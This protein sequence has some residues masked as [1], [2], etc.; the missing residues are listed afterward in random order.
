MLQYPRHALPLSL[1]TRNG[2]GP[3]DI[4]GASAALLWV[5]RPFAVTS[6]RVLSQFMRR[7]REDDTARLC[8]GRLRVANVASRVISLSHQSSLAT[9]HVDPDELEHIDD[10]VSFYNPLRW[11]PT[12]PR[13]SEELIVMGYTLDQWPATLTFR[14]KVERVEPHRVEAQLVESKMPGRLPG[15]CGAPVYR[16]GSPPEFVGVVVDSMFHN[17]L[18]HIQHAT[19]LDPFGRALTLE[20]AAQ[21]S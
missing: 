21:R 9:L 4:H 20:A 3:K 7:L 12:P 5:D 18:V 13:E 10:D 11:P 15:I 1:I 19:S 14:Y 8:L 16:V 2:A 17:E 6:G